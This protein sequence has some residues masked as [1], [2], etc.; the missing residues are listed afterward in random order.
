MSAT[1]ATTDTIIINGT[2]DFDP[3]DAVKAIAE[4]TQLMADTRSQQGCRH[5]VWSLDPAV[6]GRVYVYENWER[7]ADLAAHLKGTY[8]SGMLTLLGKY[9]MKGTDILKYQPAQA[10]PIY[11]DTGV[12]RADF[13]ATV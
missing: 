10:G 12:P 1:N 3:E 8:Y 9:E 2:V 4:A 13:F 11:D 5:Y 6:P 7:E